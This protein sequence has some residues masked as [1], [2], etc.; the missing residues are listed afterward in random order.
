[1]AGDGISD[2][3]LAQRLHDKKVKRCIG[4]EKERDNGDEL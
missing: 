1:M 2:A 4:Q 3:A